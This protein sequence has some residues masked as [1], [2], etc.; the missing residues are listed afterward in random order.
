MKPSCLIKKLRIFMSKERAIKA[1]PIVSN[2]QV[3]SNMYDL[4]D[5]VSSPLRASLTH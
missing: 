4:L 3:F 2:L 5:E 1:I